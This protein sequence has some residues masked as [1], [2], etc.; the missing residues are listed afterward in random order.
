M[1]D[2]QTETG[3]WGTWTAPQCPFAIEYSRRKL[4][5]IRLA[6]VDAFFSVPRGGLEIGG[7]LLGKFESGRLSIV[8]YRP[9]ACEHA[10]GPSFRLSTNDQ[11]RLAEAL[12]A[13]RQNTSNLQPVGWY[14]S[15]TRSEI[16]LSE[17][18]LEIHSRYFPETR[19]VA[20]VLRP[21]TFEPTRGGFFFRSPD[22]TI[23]AQSSYEEF[24]IEPPPLHAAH[25][26]PSIL[27]ASLPP[28]PTVPA[29]SAM[30][31]EKPVETA[32]LPEARTEPPEEAKPEAEA[33]PESE[34]CEIP[35]FLQAQPARS[36]RW[37]WVAALAVLVLAGAATAYQER[38]MWLPQVL[39]ATTREATSQPNATPPAQM[40][41]PIAL[42][43]TGNQGPLQIGWD[44]KSAAV[45]RAESAVLEITDGGQ[46]TEVPLDPRHLQAGAFTYL[47]RGDRVDAKLTI[48]GP[49]GQHAQATASFFGALPAAA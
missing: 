13:A 33:E 21:S 30:A 42:T 23:H 37:V 38:E 15:H 40:P 36:R 17:A 28:V 34:L 43:I 2:T 18:D 26:T 22:G 48:V 6:V 47:R 31:V 12:A 9:I 1:L 19:Q 41:A 39:A 25:P 8:D 3:S 45:E 46:A 10:L 27:S 7:V 32:L 20:L 35:A 29:E 5:E 49:G 24:V 16:F 4:E 14:H 11:S 44:P